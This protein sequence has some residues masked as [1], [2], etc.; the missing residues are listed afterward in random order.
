MDTALNIMLVVERGVRNTRKMLCEDGGA[1]K[2]R[3][4][5]LLPPLELNVIERIILST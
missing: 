4:S 1:L 2:V 3:T 5:A